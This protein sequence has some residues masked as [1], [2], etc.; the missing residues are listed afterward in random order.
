MKKFTF[1]LVVLFTFQIQQT[2]AQN[3]KHLGFEAQWYPA[4]YQLMLTHELGISEKDAFHV[5]LGY[6]IARRQDFSPYNDLENGGGWGFTLGYRHYF[7]EAVSGFYVGGRVDLWWLTIDWEDGLNNPSP[8]MGTTNITVLQPTG[9]VGYL[10]NIPDS[11]LSIGINAAAGWE[12]NVVTDGEEV[13][14]GA[15]GLLGLR[16]RYRL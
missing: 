6:N 2:H 16:L 15:I 8:T 9:E 5:K 13:G 11:P 4:G 10:Y 3:S 12:I 14:Q 7:S 1:L